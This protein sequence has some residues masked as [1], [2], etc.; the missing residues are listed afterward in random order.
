LPNGIMRM[1][2]PK[3][4]NESL[5]A[6][7]RQGLDAAE[8]SYILEQGIEGCIL[9]CD[10]YMSDPDRCGVVA[11]LSPEESALYRSDIVSFRKQV[12]KVRREAL[13]LQLKSGLVEI[14]TGKCIM[15][16]FEAVERQNL[17]IRATAGR[18]NIEE[19][20]SEVFIFNTRHRLRRIVNAGMAAMEQ[21][22]E[23]NRAMI[24]TVA[25]SVSKGVPDVT[26]EMTGIANHQFAECATRMWDPKKGT[27]FS[28][29]AWRTMH[30]KCMHA[31][32]EMNMVRLP[33]SQIGLAN[34]IRRGEIDIE[35]KEILDPKRRKRESEIRRD[36][37]N[38]IRGTTS[39]EAVADMVGFVSD[40][41]DVIDEVAVKQLLAEIIGE[42]PKIRKDLLRFR[43][44]DIGKDDEP[45]VMN[46][47]AQRLHE[48]GHTQNV[49]T[50]QRV[51]QMMDGLK[52]DV[53][54]HLRLRDRDMLVE[55]GLVEEAEQA[56]QAVGGR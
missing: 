22:Y 9:L 23:Q 31:L 55:L 24:F 3:V 40:P 52:R 50:R 16:G 30:N 19:Q 32:S 15:F 4:S 33:N 5:V 18:K 53:L 41:E 25:R 8:E 17:A 42:L 11:N 49:V 26:D 44:G 27:K 48:A 29:Y 45:G 28:T 54:R 37:L 56:K 6:T 38:S 7:I 14:V 1:D 12:E 47:I 36:V 10:L 13:R 39:M 43:V 46:E 51:Q 35:A 34:R 21:L 2:T 20:P